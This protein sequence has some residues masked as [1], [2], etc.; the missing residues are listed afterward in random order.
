MWELHPLST[1]RRTI[2]IFL[3]LEEN[4][5]LTLSQIPYNFVGLL[6]L[7]YSPLLFSCGAIT[8]W[9]HC[10]FIGKHPCKKQVALNWCC[11]WHRIGA[12]HC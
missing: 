3:L 7:S 1:N 8:A 2:E 6:F 11:K 12:Q 4:T 10:L 9:M 5:S